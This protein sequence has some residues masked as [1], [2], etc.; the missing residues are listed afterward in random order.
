[1]ARE[2]NDMTPMDAAHA[3]R[4]L[5]EMGADEIIGET[6]VDRMAAVAPPAPAVAALMASAA[7]QPAAPLRPGAPRAAIRRASLEEIAAALAALESCPLKK[8]STRLGYVDECVSAFMYLA[9]EQLA[10]YVTGQV[11]EV[12]GGQYMP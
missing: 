4:W 5:A 9:S 10:S 8:T 2:Q 11:I 3:L 6:P 12:N 7:A 1:M